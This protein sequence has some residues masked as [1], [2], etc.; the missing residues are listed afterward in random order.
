MFSK[1]SHQNNRISPQIARALYFSDEIYVGYVHGGQ[2]EVIAPDPLLGPIFY[3]IEFPSAGSPPRAVRDPSCLSCHANARTEGVPGMLVRSVVPGA[4]G[5]PIL[6]LGTHLTTHS[7]PLEERWGGWYVTGT[8]DGA[9]HMGNMTTTEADG[10]LDMEAGANWTSLEGKIDTSRYLLPTSDILA[11]MVLEHQCRMHNLL[12]R[13]SLR[14]IL[15]ENGGGEDF[16][17]IGPQERRRIADI[18]EGGLVELH[19]V[20]TIDHDFHLVG[21]CERN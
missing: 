17:H 14:E 18:L 1:T 15:L 4:D 9:L 12:T 20:V 10:T 7:S 8:H 13:A 3:L 5:R 21:E 16:S 6:R 11:L 19:L 2:I